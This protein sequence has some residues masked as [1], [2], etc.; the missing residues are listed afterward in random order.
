MRGVF[1]D[2]ILAGY[3]IL[4]PSSGDIT[5]IAVSKDYRRQ[6]IGSVILNELL[7]V[8]K[9]RAVKAVNAEIS[10]TSMKL[11]FESKNLPE[12]G[13]QFEMIRAL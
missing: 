5:Q 7:K 9:F 2:A 13:K 10:C 6:G 4:D 12:K 3:G 8:N 1:D 11:F